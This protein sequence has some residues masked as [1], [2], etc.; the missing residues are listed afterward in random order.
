MRFNY[1]QPSS[2]KKG[3]GCMI[4]SRPTGRFLMCKRATSAPYPNTWATWGGKAE[5]DETSEETAR[6]EAFEETGYRITG[7]L[8][9]LYHFGLVTF[10]FDTYVAIVE[11]EFTPRLN[12]EAEDAGWMTLEELPENVHDGLLAILED[13]ITV[14]RLIRIVE[15]TSGRPCD[16]DRIYRKPS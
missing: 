3:A 16:F 14:N 15:S 13:R 9:H 5:F 4:L 2:S 10:T 7:P 8:V 12:G 1:A 11:E 6:R